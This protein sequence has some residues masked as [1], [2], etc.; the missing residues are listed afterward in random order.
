M[1]EIVSI[2]V[3]D[4]VKINRGQL[5][6]STISPRVRGGSAGKNITKELHRALESTDFDL[7]ETV[8]IDATMGP[9]PSLRR[10]SKKHRNINLNV[11]VSE[12]E[13]ALILVDNDGYYE[14]CL[15][16]TSPSPRDQRGSRMPS[17]A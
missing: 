12:N 2:A 6:K 11:K 3:P 16:Y 15:L 10:R 14:C 5:N 9:S 13:S 1:A 17:S 8:S 7:V 4:G